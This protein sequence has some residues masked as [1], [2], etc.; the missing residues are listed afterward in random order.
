MAAE[1]SAAAE[2]EITEA[3]AAMALA[4]SPLSASELQTEEAVQARRRFAQAS[5]QLGRMREAVRLLEQASAE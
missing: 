4:L 2:A 1:A 3:L 5:S